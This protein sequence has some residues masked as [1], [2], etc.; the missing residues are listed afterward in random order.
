[1]ILPVC[2]FIVANRKFSALMKKYKDQPT[3]NYKS[4]KCTF[5]GPPRVGK[6]TTRMRL[7]EEIVNISSTGN[8][9]SDSTQLEKPITVQMYEK[10]DIAPA[11]LGFSQWKKDDW[12]G[13]MQLLL[14][15][16]QKDQDHPICYADGIQD[17]SK[18]A[19]KPLVTSHPAAKPFATSHTAENAPKAKQTL[20]QQVK[21]RVIK[22]FSRTK[23]DGEAQKQ[24][25]LQPVS[26]TH[27]T[28]PTKRIV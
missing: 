24:D 10:S 9:A 20:P 6:T 26:Y 16:V 4:L 11:V 28:L 17:D 1:M 7:M 8:T 23:R 21:S 13:E 5:I 3:I 15:H 2:T 14:Q 19:A 12:L 22:V 27:L 18:A 25:H